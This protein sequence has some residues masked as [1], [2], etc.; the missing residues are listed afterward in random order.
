MNMF[1]TRQYC[2]TAGSVVVGPFPTKA[3]AVEYGVELI[4]EHGVDTFSSRE[5]LVYGLEHNTRNDIS[6]GELV[7]PNTRLQVAS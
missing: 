2:V 1:G 4:L 5:E 3:A 6:V 7:K